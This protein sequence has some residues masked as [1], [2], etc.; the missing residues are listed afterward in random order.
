MK[1]LISLKELSNIPPFNIF[2]NGRRLTESQEIAKYI[3][4][5]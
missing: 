1:K 2:D 3:L 4:F 5:C